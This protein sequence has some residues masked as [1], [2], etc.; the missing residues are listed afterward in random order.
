MLHYTPESPDNQTQYEHFFSSLDIPSIDSEVAS[1]LDS[2]FTI[3]ELRSALMSM[4]NGKCPGPDGFPA[5]FQATISL[6]LKKDKDPLSCSNYRPISLLCADVKILA[7]MLARQ[8]E[9]VLPTIIATDQTG[10][11]KN[12]H[13]F[14]RDH[15]CQHPTLTITCPVWC[16]TH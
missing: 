1:S 16:P 3:N 8:L 12:R 10:F 5:E 11:I 15:I 14:H 6:I 7:K 4:Q 9:C 13:S 2:P